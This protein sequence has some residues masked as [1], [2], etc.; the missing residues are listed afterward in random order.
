MAYLLSETTPII[1]VKRINQEEEK[2]CPLESSI[3]NSDAWRGDKGLER[4]E[5]VK[6][7]ETIRSGVFEDCTS[8]ITIKL[9]ESL[10]HIDPNA[11]WGCTALREVIVPD[12]L[13]EV[14]YCTD[15]RGSVK[16]KTK[17]LTPEELANNL[18]KGYAM[19]FYYEGDIR[20]DF[21]D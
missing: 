12:N 9:C 17:N 4:L 20:P 5:F 15:L 19:D 11:F 1:H 16:T 18:K 14:H 13:E 3:V 21:L 7:I 10:K 6:N 8:L 2:V